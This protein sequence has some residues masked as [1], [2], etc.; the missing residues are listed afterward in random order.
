MLCWEAERRPML[1]GLF[2]FP[3][4]FY[5]WDGVI[6]S[7]S[8]PLSSQ[9]AHSEPGRA[10]SGGSNIGKL[11]DSELTKGISLCLWAFFPYLSPQ[12]FSSLPTKRAVLYETLSM[13]HEADNLLYVHVSKFLINLS[14]YLWSS[15]TMYPS[16]YLF[17]PT[18]PSIYT[19]IHTYL[20]FHPH[21]H[22]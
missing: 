20:S 1:C 22:A 16:I 21:T 10:W 11:K 17:I 15:Q 6:F 14:I 4:S 5:L 2:L 18:H 9:E 3:L 13:P 7:R 19:F 12:D 8:F